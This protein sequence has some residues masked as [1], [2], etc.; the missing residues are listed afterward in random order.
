MYK[1]QPHSSIT[2][3]HEQIQGSLRRLHLAK[4]NHHILIR[5]EILIGSQRVLTLVDTGFTYNL[6][7][8]QFAIDCIKSYSTTF[9]EMDIAPLILG[10]GSPLKPIGVLRRAAFNFIDSTGKPLSHTSDFVVLDPLNEKL[11]I[12][13]QFFME[14][15]TNRQVPRK[16]AGEIYYAK[17][18]LVFGRKLVPW[19]YEITMPA[20][21]IA[22]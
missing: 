12:G 11:I 21:H 3:S 2:D 13:H 8:K 18:S 7:D 16:S 1:R 10:D 9:E 6:L 22:R 17:Q 14:G 5:V 20:L 15:Y 19:K 4:D